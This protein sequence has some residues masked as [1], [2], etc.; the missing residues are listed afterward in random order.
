MTIIT[1]DAASGK[2][3]PC[4][5]IRDSDG[6]IW[7]G[8]SSFNDP[9][10][11]NS[12]ELATAV[13][14]AAMAFAAVVDGSDVHL[15]YELT[16]PAGVAAVACELR[17]YDGT[18]T[19]GDREEWT[20]SHDPSIASVLEDTGTTLPAAIATAQADLDILTGADGVTLATT[21]ANYA[22]NTVVPDAAGT[23]AAL[24]VTTDAAIA[25]IDTGTGS[26]ARTITVTVDDGSTALES[27][28]VRMT[29]GALS[30]TS[31]TDA[32]GSI[33]FNL[34]DGSWTVAITLAGYTYAGTTEVVTDD[35][36]PRY[37]MA[38]VSITPAPTGA[39]N[40]MIYAYDDAGA[41][42]DGVS[43]TLQCV[44]PPSGTDGLGLPPAKTLVSGADSTSGG[45]VFV[46]WPGARYT[47]RR[48][49]GDPVQFAVSADQTTDLEIDSCFE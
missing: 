22:P 34:D 40:G 26:G 5:A 31:T 29:R 18:Y 1:I 37:S 3:I 8:V 4:M 43:F 6:H 13:N 9:T 47:I 2:T 45:C 44:K 21:Q 15:G 42:L 12:T 16:L 10:S 49:D 30:Y 7:D 23:A 46:L 36:A 14:Q 33:T 17:M 19:A 32:N 20:H 35:D 39:I 28:R 25:A 41:L 11:Y 27:A 48:E 24:H 38:A